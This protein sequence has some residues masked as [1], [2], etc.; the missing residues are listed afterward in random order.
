[1]FERYIFGQC[2]QNS[3]ESLDQFVTNL[4][5]KARSC[6]FGNQEESLIRD[7]VVLGIE[8]KKLQERFLRETELSLQKA[9]D[10]GHAAEIT[11]IHVKMLQSQSGPSLNIVQK[12]S[13]RQN[14][15]VNIDK[16]KVC[17]R[18]GNSHQVR[19]CPAYRRPCLN[20]G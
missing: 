2:I 17:D 20:C 4:R 13:E 16:T 5:L 14:A 9:L 10:I 18:C 15:A 19:S 8:D 7:R 6:E 3:G 1:M 11:K 12:S